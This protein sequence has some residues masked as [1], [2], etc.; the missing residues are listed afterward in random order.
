MWNINLMIVI[1]VVL[2][3]LLFWILVGIRHFKYLRKE[4]GLLWEKVDFHLRKRHNL[5]PNLVETLRLHVSDQEQLID[6]LIESR[7]LAVKEYSC[8]AKKIEYE[9]DL[10]SDIAKLF[11]LMANLKDA[12]LLELKREISHEEKK[13]EGGTEQYNELVRKHNRH[14]E[15][16]FFRWLVSL[17]QFG[18]MD[19]FEMEKSN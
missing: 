17:F 1:G 19:I 6:K 9:H 5:I 7:A 2:F 16:W 8:N 4:I 15:M 11:G 12:N 10:S 3:I 13:A 18:R 14:R